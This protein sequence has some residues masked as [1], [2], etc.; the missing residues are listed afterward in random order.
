MTWLCILTSCSASKS[1]LC[2]AR[3]APSEPWRST[4]RL[5]AVGQEATFQL[6]MCIAGCRESQR[7][8]R[9]LDEPSAPTL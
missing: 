6:T 7:G 2:L 3:K 5:R 1:I 8:W 4:M 9:P